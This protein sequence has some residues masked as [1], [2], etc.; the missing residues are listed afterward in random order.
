MSASRAH[1]P[2]R[3]SFSPI[4]FA[5]GSPTGTPG[6]SPERGSRSSPLGPRT[7]QKTVRYPEWRHE[8]VRKARSAGLG[9]V[10]RAMEITL[11]G[12][13]PDQREQSDSDE[14]PE[15]T[16]T[17]H[18]RGRS[19]AWGEH[20]N[21]DDESD[22]EASE[23][24]WM[25]WEA[26]FFSRRARRNA[27]PTSEIAWASSWGHTPGGFSSPSP[28]T[29]NEY[30]FPESTSH[31]APEEE[32]ISPRRTLSS[33]SSA[34]S[35]LTRTIKR[36]S[37]KKRPPIPG[38]SDSPVQALRTRPRSPLA[39]QSDYDEEVT[40]TSVLTESPPAFVSHSSRQSSFGSGSSHAVA[41]AS[42]RLPMTIAMTSITREEQDEVLE[43]RGKGKGRAQDKPGLVYAPQP[44]TRK[45]SSTVQSLSPRS[46]ETA[47]AWSPTTSK[48]RTRPN[49]A[50]ATP[51]LQR[52]PSAQS[53]TAGQPETKP[54]K[55]KLN[56]SFAQ[57]T[58]MGTSTP[59]SA[60]LQSTAST[61]S[62]ESPRFAHPEESE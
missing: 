46:P 61:S 32:A 19:Q 10:S 37:P 39:E 53:Q 23:M 25:G 36:A 35:L 1:S 22:E 21:S 38:R 34:D 26:D 44:T 57:V 3:R 9:D 14:S 41:Q 59:A 47:H 24:E 49:T 17:D 60:P 52:S 7:D 29:Q 58:A 40:W 51:P 31:P 4:S 13:K 2:R 11:F 54:G 30:T 16:R 50:I 8:L 55:L 5:S 62:F 48:P 33:Y 56:L 28:H 42:A 43:G 18:K 12:R 20:P 45:R 27:S 6:A 15:R